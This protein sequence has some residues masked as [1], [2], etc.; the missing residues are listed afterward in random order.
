MSRHV[1]G[2]GS[3]DFPC[4][5][6]HEQNWQSYPVNPCSAI[7]D[8]HTYYILY[9]I[10]YSHGCAAINTLEYYTILYYINT[11]IV[12]ATNTLEYYTILYYTNTA[13][14]V[15]FAIVV[16]KSCTLSNRLKCIEKD[17]FTAYWRQTSFN[18]TSSWKIL[19]GKQ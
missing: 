19:P 14:D 2:Q 11:F 3:A 8:D 13:K 12:E 7:G 15:A 17:L 16:K 9:Y 4:S 5:A 18:R 10:I 1:R 6:D